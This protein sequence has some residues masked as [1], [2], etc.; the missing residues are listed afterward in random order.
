MSRKS[1]PPPGKPTVN[2]LQTEDLESTTMRKVAWRLVPFLCLIYVVAFI[3]RINIGFAALTMSKD[4]GLTPAMF[5][6][7]AG[8]FFIGYFLFEVPSNLILHRVGARRWIARVMITWGIISTCFTL[9]HSAGSFYVLRF[10]LGV[11]EAGFFPGIILYL[12]FWFPKRWRGQVTAGFMSAIPVASFIAAPV[13]GVLL[14]MNAIAGFKGWQWMFIVEGV[15]SV[16]LGFVVLKFLT[17]APAKAKWLKTE[18]RDWLVKEMAAESG[19]PERHSLKEVLGTL[20]SWKVMQLALVYFGLTTGLYGIELWMPQMLKGF[21]LSDLHVGFV[22][23]IPYLVAICTMGF[24]AKHSDKMGE[25]Y[26]HVS[27]GLLVLAVFAGNLLMKPAT[28]PVLRRFGFR[29]VLIGNGLLVATTIFACALFS[30]STPTAIIVVVL[31]AGG[32]FRSMQFTGLTSLGFADIQQSL[33]SAAST[34]SSMVQQMT[35]GLGVAFGAIALR[36]AGLFH[37]ANGGSLTVGD[38]RIAFS[39]AGLVALVAV[40]D[41]LGLAPNAGTEVSGH[42]PVEAPSPQKS[43]AGRSDEFIAG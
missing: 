23:A 16:I 29:T 38:L 18:Q 13:S 10:L 30:A 3:D 41:C 11:A 39:L 36:L 26:W 22:S 24:W 15:P 33:M 6:L 14:Q 37:S 1:D 25:R 12:S 42:R 28:T 31:F 35:F 2:L 40:V 5:G 27:S 7:G 21:G 43:R 19:T 9:I 32:L 34:L 4:L 20:I 8:I 17:D